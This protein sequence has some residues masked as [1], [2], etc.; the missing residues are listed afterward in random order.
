MT[1]AFIFLIM[2]WDMSGIVSISGSIGGGIYENE[3]I[4]NSPGD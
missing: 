4:K 1:I 2:R 3:Q